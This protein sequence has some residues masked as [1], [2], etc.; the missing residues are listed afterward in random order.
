MMC[1]KEKHVGLVQLGKIELMEGYTLFSLC[2]GRCKN[3]NWVGL[4]KYFAID[5]NREGEVVD[6]C[7]S[8]SLNGKYGKMIKNLFHENRESHD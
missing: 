3:G 6:W 7:Q 1:K 5:I 8:Q 4:M 2:E